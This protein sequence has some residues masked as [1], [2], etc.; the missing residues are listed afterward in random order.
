[1][2][3]GLVIPEFPTQ[4]HVFFWREI[5]ALRALGA[6]VRILSTRR[7]ALPCPHPFAA[8][9]AA[10]TRYLWPFSARDLLA[11]ARGGALEAARY[12]GA[13]SGARG[14]GVALAAAGAALAAEAR[15]QRIDHLHAHSAADTAHVAALA[16]R[17]GGPP[18]SVH[19]HGDLA[20][21][22][23]DHA[24][25][26][27]GAAFV[28]AA[29]APLRDQ[30]AALGYPAERIHVMPMAVDTG[31]F[32]PREGP[33]PAGPFHVV[34]VSRLA[35]CKGHRYALAALAT[36]REAGHA[37]RYTIAGDGPDR[38]AIEADVARLG[39][40]A[41][42]TFAGSLAEEAVVALLRS[43]DAFVL[44]SVGLGESYPVAAQEAMACGLPVVATVIGGTPDMITD[45]ADGLLVPQAAPL[46]LAHALARLA[47]DPALRER[48]GRAAHRRAVAEFDVRRRA[49][50]FLAA[51]EAVRA[52]A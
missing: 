13:L 23:A 7:P 21:Y 30:V 41:E 51:V 18:Y 15:R 20:V 38:P 24:L 26:L 3:L 8:A 45:G 36:L 4:T 2:R 6:D 39:L 27:S 11:G 19:V 50:A 40:G 48:L 10:E 35:L 44:P 52:A 22:G 17:L 14:R 9:A 1:M 47:G 33:R 43:A 25:K 16:R 28:A 32:T 46:P 31:R 5:L 37:V 12:V 29:T 49:R 34:T 42:V